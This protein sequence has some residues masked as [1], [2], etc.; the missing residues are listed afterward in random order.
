MKLI[1]LSVICTLF[2]LS[3]TAQS[4]CGNVNSAESHVAISYSNVDIYKEGKLVASVLTDREGNFNVPLDTG[5]YTCV[6]SYSGF[7]TVTKELTV[8]S[9]EKEEFNVVADK[10]KKQP[11]AFT[12]ASAPVSNGT[13]THSM[14][15]LSDMDGSAKRY[16]VSGGTE[17]GK[18][19]SDG[20]IKSY[21][22]KE[23]IAYDEIFTAPKTPQTKAR[24]G[25]LTAGEINDFSKW[26]LWQDIAST[27]LATYQTAWNIAPKGRYTLMLQSESGIPLADAVVSLIDGRKTTLFTARTD[28]TGK[29]ELWLTI[30]NENPV[31][32]GKLS[33]LVNY[34][35]QS[36]LIERVTAFEES[37]NH[38]KLNVTCEQTEN[39][40]IA[41]VVDA[42]G[43][44]GDEL[45]Y[46]KA[47]MNDIVFQS[48]QIDSK[49][50]FRFANVFYRDKGVNELYLTRKMDF[51]RVLSESVAYIDEQYAGGGGDYEEAVETALD[52]A[53]NELQWSETARTRVLF[54][55]LDAPPHNTPETQA[56][57]QTLMNQAAEKGIRIVPIGASGI[58]KS[59]E[60]LMRTLALG[61]NGTYT[62]LTNHSGIGSYHID[63]TTDKF[64]VETLNS[65]LV[66]I[67]KSYT[68]MPDCD[69]QLP[70]LA[71]NYPD[72]IVQYPLPVDT[73]TS[74]N[75]TIDTNGRVIHHNPPVD[76]VHVT[77]SYYPN[78]TNG[79][80]NIVSD[81]D[82][83]EL[84]ITDLTGKLLQVL[85]KIEAGRTVQV[86]LSQY[87]TG[88]YLIRYPV[89][90]NWISGKVVLQR[91]S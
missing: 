72:S 62:F 57:L 17:S 31:V 13:E 34:H 53:I 44:M 39:V 74:P 51:N 66:R 47:E 88:I 90:K 48:K 76:S 80:V 38:L 50:N 6:V 27:D 11:R 18:S 8:K 40:D 9:N 86:D 46:L 15:A 78:P 20:Y 60:Y 14:R 91:N 19:E 75:D 21:D 12:E 68:Y 61:T 24:S 32:N 87:A 84:Y 69:Q 89:G 2:T 64:D 63:P 28:N 30:K 33:I 23:V 79:I 5:R 35:G 3:A 77:W 55:I 7:H 83:E 43:S 16:H 37:I 29:A 82:I 70:D 67:M 52:V 73:V 85:P 49:L 81:T 42:T 65:L 1:F 71:L 10:T 59:T 58:N 26:K 56:K 54:L 4:L 45:S 22:S 25:A 41:F 36:K